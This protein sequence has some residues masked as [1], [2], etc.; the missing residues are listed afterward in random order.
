MIDVSFQQLA[1]EKI[2]T[3]IHVMDFSAVFVR[4]NSFTVFCYDQRLGFKRN[5]RVGLEA[6]DY[7]NKKQ[8]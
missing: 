3:A 8:G 7:Y 2:D 1:P 6:F 4:T 5:T